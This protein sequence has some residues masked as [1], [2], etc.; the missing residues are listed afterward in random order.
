MMKKM[1][2]KKCGKA[3]RM[4]LVV[5]ALLPYLF[6][7]PSCDAMKMVDGEVEKV[8]LSFCIA[9]GPFSSY[10][11]GDFYQEGALLKS[12]GIVKDTNDFILKVYSTDGNKIYHGK[13]GT[14][15]KD[16]MVLPGGYEI[17]LYSREFTSPKFDIPVF[18][19][20]LTTIVRENEQLAIKFHCRQI[21]GGLKITFSEDFKKKFPG[22]GVHIVQGEGKLEYKYTENRYAYLTADLFS[23]VYNGRGGDTILLEKKINAAQMVDMKLTYT[24]PNGHN[25]VFTIEMDTAR[26]WASDHQNIGLRLP[27]GTVTIEEAKK[28]VGE[29]KV[30]VFGFI[31]GGDP[32]TT[33]IRI[34]PP[35]TSTATL[36]I[37]PSMSERNRNNCFVVELPS[38]KIRDDLNLVG[39]PWHLGRGI[40]VTGD[41]VP[42][43]FDYTGI[44]G[45]KSYTFIK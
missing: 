5:L 17:A 16:F 41:I 40:I 7:I 18:G 25:S 42:S 26:V 33:A 37:A 30:S 14:K 12:N 20:T 19:D 35:F 3:G 31:Y 28:M 39:R 21:S 45:T 43:Y 8:K 15:P 13:Y 22:T 24:I 2:N 44:K 6:L 36:V 1:K 9:P 11:E 38:G 32:T 29:K 23:L 34:S 4:L 27:T 10:K